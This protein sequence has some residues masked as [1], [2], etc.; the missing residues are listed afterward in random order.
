MEPFLSHHKRMG[1]TSLLSGHCIV[2]QEVNVSRLRLVHLTIR[3]RV[4]ARYQSGL[5]WAVFRAVC[6]S[7]LSAC[8]M[9]LM[10]ATDAAGPIGKSSAILVY[11]ASS[12]IISMST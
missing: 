8:H 5:I 12:K 2:D 6:V 4:E 10:T 3:S 7:S 1:E 9:V 11:P